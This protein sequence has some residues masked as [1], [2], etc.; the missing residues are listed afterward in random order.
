MKVMILSVTAGNGH[1][2]TAKA[3]GDMLISKGAEVKI[4]DTYEYVN[5]VVQKAIDKGY[6]LSIKHT[7]EL[8][9]LGYR[10]AEDYGSE[11]VINHLNLINL[12]NI[13]GVSKFSDILYDYSPD[14]IV[15]T[16]VFA[17][18]LV[19]E[20]KKRNLTDVFTIG[21]ITDYTIHP[22]WENVPFINKIV[23]ASSLLEY[24]AIK[25]GIS[26]ECLL[27]YGIPVNPK[28]N[29][30]ISKEIACKELGIE[31]SKPTVLLMGGGLGY[32]KYLKTIKK[33]CKM[34]IDMQLLVVCGS[35]KKQFDDIQFYLSRYTGSI[36]IYLYSFVNNVDIMMSVSDCI[37]TKPGGLTVSE[38][39]VKNLPLI[40]IK[41]IPGQEERNTE[42]LLNSGVALKSSS[43]SYVDECVYQLL[44]NN[45]QRE[46]MRE[47]MNLLTPKNAT[48]NLCNYIMGI[49]KDGHI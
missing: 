11:R 47:T 39:L 38:A 35:N 19:N 12:M 44:R 26:K 24:R 45:V 13:I 48:E 46:R 25:R 41:P 17:A 28:F 29:E 4:I 22:Y 1:N 43:T 42:F 40:L 7:K 34:D 18:Q 32:G 33:L 10:F 36:K 37:I 20:L 30:N 8:Y 2:A 21:I 14:V 16:H 9:R 23:L 31:I 5:K 49:K 27:S 15:C 3:I 6:T